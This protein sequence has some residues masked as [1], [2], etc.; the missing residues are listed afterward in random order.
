MV[1]NFRVFPFTATDG[2]EEEKRLQE[3]LFRNYNKH[4]R[5]VRNI[6][7]T[8]VL[9]IGLSITQL[10][11]VDEKNQ[12]ITTGVWM[13]QYWIDYRLSWNSSNY[14]GMDNVIIPFDWV[15]YPDIV[16]D[17]SADG[18][19]ELPRW[20]YTTVYSDGT[21]WVTPPGVLKSP[22][23]IDV[24][25][26]PFDIQ[27][28]HMSF[29]PWEFTAVELRLTPVEDFVVIENYVKNVEWELANSSVLE[30]Y[31]QNECCPEDAYSVVLYTLVLRRRPLFYVLNIL[32]PCLVMSMLT[33]VVFYLPS[34]CGEKMTLSISVLLA[35]SVFNLLI[36]DI[37]PPT[38]DTTPLIGKYLL[39]NMGLVMLSIMFSVIV[40]NLHH[41]S[42]R[43]CR[44]PQWVR[45]FFLYKLPTYVCLMPYPFDAN[46]LR[47]DYVM[48]GEDDALTVAPNVRHSNL[49]LSSLTGSDNMGY[50][51]EK[52]T[53]HFKNDNRNLRTLSGKV[54][55]NS[56]RKV[57]PTVRSTSVHL[58]KS[59][60]TNATIPLDPG[61][62]SDEFR[63]NLSNHEA[64][65][66]S[67]LLQNKISQELE[68]VTRRLKFDDWD[69]EVREEWKF[70]AMVTDRVCLIM[71]FII[72]AS[73]TCAILLSAPNI[74]AT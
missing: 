44:M 71:F 37:M 68:F 60:Q 62:Y 20:K 26:F 66:N 25:Y 38:S 1:I 53:L 30:I 31:E 36:F 16:L 55:A 18:N 72:A 21:V 67:H 69:F 42:M 58:D 41:R 61:D 17:N 4:V 35:L 14:G 43:T 50:L 11:D 34:D 65:I 23:A 33:L 63:T 51:D 49:R 22:C 32:V 19:Y 9:S 27:E 52:D 40:L 54:I 74:S 48:S 2:A 15:W 8:V 70:V 10:L 29:G 13:N 45:R 59:C 64:F 5:P 46:K 28:C 24:Q 47:N 6:S 73:G 7:D 12:I 39:F 57:C 3:D 56:R